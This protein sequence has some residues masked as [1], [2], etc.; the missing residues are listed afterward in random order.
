ML[1]SFGKFTTGISLNLIALAALGWVGWDAWQRGILN[2][3]DIQPAAVNAEPMLAQARQVD[4]N[5][6]VRSHLFGREGRAPKPVERTAPPTRLN[7]KLVGIIA[8]GTTSQGIA[9]IETGRGKQQS[10][11]VGQAIGTTDALLSEVARD[12][13]LIERNGKLEKLAI[14]RPELESQ[15]IGS[16]EGRPE[17]AGDDDNANLPVASSFEPIPEVA[18]EPQPEPEA[19][20]QTEAGSQNETASQSEGNRRPTRR[21]AATA[22]EPAPGEA[23]A[24]VAPPAGAVTL[25]F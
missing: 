10:V 23:T 19:A 7:L 21:N 9:L 17:N 13:V 2:G 5:A 6:I 20:S 1:S 15:P 24:G 11:R 22:G 3:L 4:V 18:R 8:I 12:H 25:P 16:P 14:K